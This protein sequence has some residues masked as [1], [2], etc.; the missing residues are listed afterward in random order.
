[1]K[2]DEEIGRKVREILIG[3]AARNRAKG[4]ALRANVRA[5]WEQHPDYTAKQI[6]RLLTCGPSPSIRRV[7]EIVKGLRGSD[8]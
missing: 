8:S 3:Q 4:E 5:I 6:I 1:M 2:T 7:Q